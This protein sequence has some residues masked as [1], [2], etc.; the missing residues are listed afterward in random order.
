[1]TG[2][3]RPKQGFF[4]PVASGEL[5]HSSAKHDEIIVQVSG[6]AATMIGRSKVAAAV[7]GGE[8]HTWKLP[9]VFTQKKKMGLGG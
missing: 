6:D 1:M 4:R 2:F 7:Y 9:G 8:K 3:K 5:S